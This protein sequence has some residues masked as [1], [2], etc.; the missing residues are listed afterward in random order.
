[1]AIIFFCNC[2][3]D[4]VEI[5]NWLLLALASTGAI[6]TI[7]TYLTSIRQ[8]KIDNTFKTLDYL[9]VHISDAQ[10]STFIQ[11]FQANNE[12]SGV[13]FNE[14]KFEDDVTDTIESMFSE[15]G[16]GNGDIQNII[17]LFNLVCPTLVD[18]EIK[19]IWFEYGQ[20]MGKI[21]GWTK[22]LEEKV[23]INGEI[24]FY[25]EFN[26]FMKNNLDKMEKFPIKYYTYGG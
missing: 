26:K 20:I 21:Y 6:I 11:L 13:N 24:E 14:F 4:W 16:C 8:R 19:L 10:I 5:R 17:E 9:R 22:Y 18:L 3:I 25:I 15:G 23:D 7:K 1:M 2:D 12:S